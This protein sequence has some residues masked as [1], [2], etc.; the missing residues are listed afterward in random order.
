[1]NVGIKSDSITGGKS[2]GKM[3]LAIR[4]FIGHPIDGHTIE[5]LPN[6][7]RNNRRNSHTIVEAKENQKGENNH[8]FSA[9][10]E[11]YG[12][13]ETGKTQTVSGQGGH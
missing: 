6:Q 8:T 12:I 4:G 2:G 9:E 13:S 10:K 3:I 11:R 7:M 1:M 5:P